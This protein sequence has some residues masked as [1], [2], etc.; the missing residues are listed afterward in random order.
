MNS[1]TKTTFLSIALFV[2]GVIFV[3]AIYPLMV[4]WPSGWQWVPNQHDYEQ[5]IVGVYATL[6]FFLIRASR[7]P[8][9]NLSL[10][11]FTAWSSLIHGGIMA[12][13]AVSDRNDLG[14]LYGDV[15]ALIIV[16][17]VLAWLTPWTTELE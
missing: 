15:P 12:Y 13:Q 3:F 11:W 7:N 8:L 6:G 4:Y 1:D 5:M 2:I 16:F 14:H 10:I 9:K 17:I